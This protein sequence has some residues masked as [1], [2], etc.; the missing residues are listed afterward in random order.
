[1]SIS[2]FSHANDFDRKICSIQYNELSLPDQF[3]FDIKQS[4]NPLIWLRNIETRIGKKVAGE[5][6]AYQIQI[7]GSQ[8]LMPLFP[9]VK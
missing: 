9:W 2:I 8:A 6:Q 1:M 7:Y 5:G 3:N 4:Y